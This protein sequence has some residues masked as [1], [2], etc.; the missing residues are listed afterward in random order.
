MKNSYINCEIIENI[1]I[2]KDVY[3]MKVKFQEDIISGQFFMLKSWQSS[4]P[5]LARPISICDVE[6]E[7]ITFLYIVVGEGTKIFTKLKPS[8]KIEVLGPLGKGFD[9]SLS[10]KIALVGGGIGIAPLYLLGKRLK[11][12][13][14]DTYLG[15]RD[16][17]YFTKEFEKI[18]DN[19]TIYTES[20]KYGKKGFVTQDL[21]N[22]SYDYIFSCGPMPMFKSLINVVDN[23]KTLYMSLEN[24]MG[25]GIGACL[26]CSQKTKNGMRTVCKNGPV[27][28]AEEVIL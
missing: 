2:A 25:C 4:T 3:K 9:E 13:T 16:E 8:D 24:R 26:S 1:K 22:K 12:S 20:G 17:I 18:S 21:T 14:I 10:G 5:L 11:Y 6:R 15:F 27:F 23:K 7:I 28:T 19:I